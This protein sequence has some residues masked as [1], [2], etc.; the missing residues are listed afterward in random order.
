VKKVKDGQVVRIQFLD[1]VEGD[2]EPCEFE[3]F[4]RVVKQDTESTT[5]VSWAF[6]GERNRADDSNVTSFCIV[7][8]AIKQI[9]TL[10]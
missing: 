9:D 1:H 8:K 5:V 7:N 3:V 2:D 4:G 10:K 6:V